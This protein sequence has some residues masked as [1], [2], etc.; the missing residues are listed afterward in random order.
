LSFAAILIFAEL[1]HTMNI[2]FIVEFKYISLLFIICVIHFV[3]NGIDG[4]LN[5]ERKGTSLIEKMLYAIPIIVLSMMVKLNLTGLPGFYMANLGN[6][7]EDL[8]LK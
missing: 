5:N 3:T 1:Q 2:Y 7:K 4:K 6:S 8:P